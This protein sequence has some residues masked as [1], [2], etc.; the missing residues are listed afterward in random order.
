[1]KNSFSVRLAETFASIQ[2]EGLHAGLVCFFIR[3]AGCNLCCSYCDTEYARSGGKLTDIDTVI[4]LWRESRVSLVQVTGGEPLLQ[5]GVY[6]LMDRLIECGA[7]VLLE[8]NGSLSVRN[9]PW[10]VV[11]VVDVKTPGSGVSDCWH[12]ENLRWLS[13][14]DQLKFV[15][16]GRDD[17]LWACD[18][19]KR[20]N[21]TA[22]CNVLF[23][24]AWGGLEPRILAEWILEDRLSVRF[25]IQLHKVLWGE[26]TTR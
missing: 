25:Q 18:F 8:T 15:L 2:G 21:L 4:D 20:H 1:M 13:S 5:E 12:E 17:Y 19:V 24:A 10:K 3:L 9:V 11:K 6:P 16:T 23:S 7:Q 14:R 26:K 22:F